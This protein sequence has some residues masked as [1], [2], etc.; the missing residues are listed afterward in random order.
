MPRLWMTWHRVRGWA[1]DRVTQ[2]PA[3]FRQ[4]KEDRGADILQTVVVIAIFV[5][6]A[7]VIAGIIIS[8]ATDAATNIQT[9]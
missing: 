4:R 9:Q 1:H 3:L 5:A 7:I 6:A 8:K 2:A